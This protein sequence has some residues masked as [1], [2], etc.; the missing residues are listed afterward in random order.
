M[1]ICNFADR[2]EQLNSYLAHL[3]GHFDSPKAI[4]ST[5]RIKPFDKA[6]LAQLILRMCHP[7]WQDQY[8]LT[9]GFIPQN[10]HST[11]EILKNIKNF[12]ES[13]NPPGKPNRKPGENVKSDSK[14]CKVGFK[15]ERVPK[16]SRTS[17]T[18][19]FARN[20]GVHT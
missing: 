13:F 7:K 18:V 9:Q 12:Q 6:E 20:M 11:I 19:T 3:P 17:K 5:K 1:T 10:L 8:N 16:K 2:V 15:E 14:I 4:P